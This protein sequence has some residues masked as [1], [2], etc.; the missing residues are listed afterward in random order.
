MGTK[1]V[2]VNIL[3]TGRVQGVF[4]RVWCKK[5]AGKLGVCG[6]AKNLD[7]GRVEVVAEGEKSKLMELIKLIKEGPKLAKVEGV[8]VNWEKA[9]GEFTSF[10]ISY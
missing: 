1:N 3:I 5:Q 2:R 4:Y 7:D 10:E 6:W 8:D 9:T